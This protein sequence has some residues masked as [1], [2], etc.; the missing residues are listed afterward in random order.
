MTLPLVKNMISGGI[1]ST[2]PPQ[3][4]GNQGSVASVLNGVQKFGFMHKHITQEYAT[5]IDDY[6]TMYGYACKKVKVPN[7]SSRPEWNYVKTIACKIRGSMPSDDA[8]AIEKIYDSGIRFWKNPGHI[9][10]YT[11]DNSPVTVPDNPSVPSEE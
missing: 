11:F 3:A 7:R 1:Q 6:F 10:N 8:V 2:R 5:I 9:G 4:Q